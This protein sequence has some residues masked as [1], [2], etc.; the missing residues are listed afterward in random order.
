MGDFNFG[1]YTV[2]NEHL[3]KE[4]KD[5]WKEYVQKQMDDI[6]DGGNLEDDG[7][8][9]YRRMI[10]MG[11]S[12]GA[13]MQKMKQEGIS[14]DVVEKFSAL[15][16]LPEGGM[17]MKM[18]ENRGDTMGNQRYDRVLIKSKIWNVSNFEIIGQPN[19]PSDHL[20]VVATIKL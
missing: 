19:M 6:S 7:L 20:G 11:V 10:Q 18:K 2:E 12:N 16:V 13:I 4:Y 8:D 3:S 15:G 1:D 17:Y 9:K 5:C 14:D